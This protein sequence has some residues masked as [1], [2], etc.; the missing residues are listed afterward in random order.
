M[1]PSAL[2]IAL[3][4]AGSMVEVIGRLYPNRVST[5]ER[6]AS[7]LGRRIGGRALLT[8]LWV[9]VGFHLFARYTIPH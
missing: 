9:F 4:V 7:V 2:W 3:L 5:L 6:A 1:N 8:A